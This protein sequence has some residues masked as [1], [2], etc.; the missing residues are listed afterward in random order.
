MPDPWLASLPDPGEGATAAFRL[1]A[2]DPAWDAFV[3]RVAPG[4]YAQRPA[5][6]E[7]KAANGWHAERVVVDA[8]PGP[9]GAQL[10]IHRLGPTPWSIGYAPR[11]PVAARFEPAAVTAWT[12]ALRELARRRRLSHVVV[13]PA[14][15]VGDQVADWLVANGWRP[16]AQVQPPRTRLID[17]R[18]PEDEL[19]A[20]LRSKWRQYVTRA[21]RDGVTVVETGPDGLD[22]F[23]RIYVETARRAGFIH[24]A[25]S[26]Y[27]ATYA[28]FA[29]T[30]A[31]RLLFAQGP[32]GSRQATLMLLA[33]GATVVEPYGGMTA[34]GATSRAN[35]LLKWEAI[36]S[37]QAGGFTTYDLWGLAHPGIAQF[38]AGF[39]GREVEWIGA[40]ELVA[41][42]LVR[43]TVTSIQRA[44]VALAVRRAGR[45]GRSGEASGGAAAA[46]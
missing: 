19:W 35:Y 3:A 2:D 21:R 15:P 45:D 6:A 43:G 34:A 24:R 16:T 29:R 26:A 22:D 1:R 20:D 17:L 8:A 39:G 18:R 11:G 32:D 12:D 30:G 46:P 4:A 5:W 10:L 7:V 42:P 9:I 31:A 40:W 44:R 13:D 14:I 25:A 38:K 41:R 37:S 27:G 23:F 36:R 28:A 33:C